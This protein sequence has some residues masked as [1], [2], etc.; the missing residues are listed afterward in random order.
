MVPIAFVSEHSETLVELDI[1]YAKTARAAGVKAYVR[2]PAVGAAPEFIEGLADLVQAAL[3]RGPPI[4]P[5]HGA[6]LCP[7]ALKGCP[8]RNTVEFV[9]TP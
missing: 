4:G 1:E 2:V 3:R 9:L 7:A 5:A 8:C 6:R